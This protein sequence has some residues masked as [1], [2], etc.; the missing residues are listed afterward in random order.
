M[1]SRPFEILNIR[2]ITLGGGGGGGGGETR[3]EI[4]GAAS[5]LFVVSLETGQFMTL[6]T[7]LFC[8]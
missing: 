4:L 7:I 1:E 6:S 3:A 2:D 5:Q 8:A